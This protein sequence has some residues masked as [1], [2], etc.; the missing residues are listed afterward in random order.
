MNLQHTL[1]G[2]LVG[3]A[4]YYLFQLLPWKWSNKSKRIVGI[5]LGIITYNIVC[6]L[7]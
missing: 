6:W 4:V 3:V 7:I 2:L 5:A 1:Y